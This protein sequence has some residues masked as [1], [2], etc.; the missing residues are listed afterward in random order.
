MLPFELITPSN[1]PDYACKIFFPNACDYWPPL[2]LEWDSACRMLPFNDGMLLKSMRSKLTSNIHEYDFANVKI[3]GYFQL[4][5]YVYKIGSSQMF[6]LW[7]VC[8]TAFCG[9]MNVALRVFLISPPSW[10]L[11]LFEI[12]VLFWRPNL[13]LR[14]S[15]YPIIKRLGK[16]Y[17]AVKLMVAKPFCTAS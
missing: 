15:V 13:W 12:F 7:H 16:W 14:K 10:K 17:P 4:L 1:L 6:N 9:K 3:C 2:F 11:F 8:S 5:L